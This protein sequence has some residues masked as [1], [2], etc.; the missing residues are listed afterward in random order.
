MGVEVIVTEKSVCFSVTIAVSVIF[1][2]FLC[3]VTE[4]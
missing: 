4:K 1:E 2:V 3:V